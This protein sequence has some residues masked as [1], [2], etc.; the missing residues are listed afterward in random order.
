MYN[1]QTQQTCSQIIIHNELQRRHTS[2]SETNRKNA[3]LGAGDL[4]YNIHSIM[5]GINYLEA[6]NKIKNIYQEFVTRMHMVI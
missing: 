2:K 1:R 5:K 3:D 4:L 6:R